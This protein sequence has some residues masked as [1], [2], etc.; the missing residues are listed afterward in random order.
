MELW[1]RDYLDLEGLAHI[2]FDNDR[3][4]SFQFGA[5]RGW[6]DYRVSTD[7]ASLRVDFSWE[8]TNDADPS[9]GRGWAAIA[10]D[11]LVGRL[12]FHSGDDGPRNGGSP[13]RRARAVAMNR[14][15]L[16]AFVACFDPEYESEQPAHPD[17][18]F[19]G[20]AQVERN[21]AAMFA[22]VPEFRAEVARSAV[23]ADTVWVEW[24]WTGSR[25]D[26]TRLDARGACIF[27]VRAGRLRWG[28]LYME[29]VESG[30][31][32]EAA[33]ASLARGPAP[34]PER[35]DVPPSAT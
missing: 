21:W 14:Q 28:R 19:R 30:A 34:V 33:V 9:C 25:G 6:I 32:I 22:G 10:D 20:R 18:L 24:R 16:A 13:S 5:V 2:T 4:G 11:K 31:G 12:Y 7:G 15:D 26:G 23:A 35:R 29:D 27:G 1:D 3:L 17:R 8:G